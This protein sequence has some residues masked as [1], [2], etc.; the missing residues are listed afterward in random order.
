MVKIEFEIDNGHATLYV[1]LNAVQ[2][3]KLIDWLEKVTS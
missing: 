1:Y 2:R 3:R